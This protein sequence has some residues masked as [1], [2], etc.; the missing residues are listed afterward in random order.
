MAGAGPRERIID[1][2]ALRDY[3]DDLARRFTDEPAELRAALWRDA[4]RV[5][6]KA[7]SK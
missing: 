6:P 3:L 1:H 4:S 7:A 2:R 5:W